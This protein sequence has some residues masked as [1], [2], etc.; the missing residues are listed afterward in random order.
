[1]ESSFEEESERY[2]EIISTLSQQLNQLQT[3]NL[4]LKAEGLA[5]R[6]DEIAERNRLVEEMAAEIRRQSGVIDELKEREGQMGEVLT[7]YQQEVAALKG[8][9][10]AGE[11]VRLRVRRENDVESASLKRRIRFLEEQAKAQGAEETQGEVENLRAELVAREVQVAF[12]RAE[13]ERLT[14]F[15]SPSQTMASQERQEW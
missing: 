8:Q 4:A 13:I 14:K 10:Q 3:H 9:V 5:M 11:E 6:E 2:K 15:S 7:Q 1:M 12:C